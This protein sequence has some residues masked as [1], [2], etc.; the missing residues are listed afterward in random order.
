MRSNATAPTLAGPVRAHSWISPLSNELVLERL[1]PSR[2]PLLFPSRLIDRRECVS[3]PRGDQARMRE[4]RLTKV[5][6]GIHEGIGARRTIRPTRH[7]RA[8]QEEEL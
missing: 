6:G 4:G 5:L 1:A 7:R 3:S 2:P 8:D